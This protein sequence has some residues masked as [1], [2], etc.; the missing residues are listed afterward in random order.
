[1]E[2]KP[3]NGEQQLSTN[4]SAVNPAD[5]E[6][7]LEDVDH[8]RWFVSG[9]VVGYCSERPSQPVDLRATKEVNRQARLSVSQLEALVSLSREKRRLVYG[10][11][12]TETQFALIEAYEDLYRPQVLEAVEATRPQPLQSSLFGSRRLSS[13]RPEKTT[14]QRSL[15]EKVAACFGLVSLVVGGWLLVKGE[16]FEVS[17]EST[18]AA[19][20]EPDS[21]DGPIKAAVDG[22]LD[23]A[24][25]ISTNE[26]QAEMVEGYL[27]VSDSV[28]AFYAQFI[29]EDFAAAILSTEYTQDTAESLPADSPLL[30]APP[31]SPQMTLPGSAAEQAELEELPPAEDWSPSET[32]VVEADSD[33]EIADQEAVYLLGSEKEELLIA[34]GIDPADW[35]YVDFI[36]E[37][38]SNWRPFVWNEQGSPAYGLCQTMTTAHSD[39]SR[40][41]YPIVDIEDFM[42]NPVAQLRWC[43][44]YALGKYGSWQAAYEF[45]LEKGWW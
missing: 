40:T 22:W 42:K 3:P 6:Q 23:S 27:E 39:P 31:E 14:V 36:L 16:G 24:A 5:Q 4:V 19:V 28:S 34:A 25:E 20:S 26:Q 41:K 38:E 32:V 43:N 35:Q 33:L 12:L 7:L 8:W 30:S 9:E 1:M 37:K 18:V 13:S 21:V 17:Q 11:N 44:S 45:W 15:S 29:Q 10:D 2:S